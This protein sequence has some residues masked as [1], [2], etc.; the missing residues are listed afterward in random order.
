MSNEAASDRGGKRKGA[1]GQ[2]VPV[3]T[4]QAEAEDFKIRRRTIGIVESPA[5]VVVR[6]RIDSQ[7]LEQ[8]VADGQLVHKG[9][10]LFILD[11]REIQAQIA[12]DQA[13]LAKDNAGLAQAQADLGRKQ[14]LIEKNV[15][16]QQQLD[17]ATSAYKAAQQTVEADEAVLQADRLKLGYARLEAPITGRVG[18]IRVTPGNLVGV[19]DTAG[20]VTITQ[21]EPIRAGFALAERDLAALR[22]AFARSPPAEVRVYAPG[23]DKLLATG[24]LDFVDSSV[25]FSSGTIAAKAKFANEK[26]ELWPGMYVDIEVDLDVRPKTVMIPAV[27]VQSGQKGPFVFVTKGGQTVEMRNVEL[28]GSEA[29][30]LALAKGVEAGEKVVVEGQMRLTN[31]TRVRETAPEDNAPA[32]KQKDAERESDGA[33]RQ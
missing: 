24:T 6:A 23:E 21:I 28:A 25:D 4:A 2:P 18:A 29:N 22:K 7:V 15:A 20:L 5:I 10:L 13:Q 17:Q 33:V 27:A 32:S 26:L 16:P 8:H 30:R 31:G 9:D 11:D 12:R 19:N 3:I 14:E 1:S